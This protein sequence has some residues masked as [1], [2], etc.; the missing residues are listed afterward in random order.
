MPPQ[1]DSGAT[2]VD[3]SWIRRKF[4]DC[5]YGNDPRQAV[6]IYLPNDGAGPFPIV[7]FVHGG[8]WM[9]GQKDD[10]QLA[11]FIGG[12]A[13]GYAVVSI[14]YRL[15]PDVRYPDNLFD[16]KAALRWVARNAGE[17]M[18]D[19]SRTALCGDSAGAHLAMMA[20]FT[21]GVAVF[22][23]VAGEPECNVLAVVE[24][25]GPT[26]FARIY[27]HFEESGVTPAM[28]PGEPSAI[29]AMLGA[30]AE[31]IPNLLRFYNPI[32]NVHPGVPPVLLQHGMRD[33][34]IPY[35]QAAVLY[36]KITAVAGGGMAELDVN[37]SYTH[38]DPGYASP[39]S[40]ERIY[41]FIG[42]YL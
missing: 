38:A 17:Y 6:D 19:P 12:A 9:H 31:L 20:A 13:R 29:D 27:E 2:L 14:G 28:N 34:I 18:L 35:Q 8:T 36:E 7:F 1:N 26:D 42:K 32:D 33:S 11:P 25:F 40:V 16:V 5:R 23:D 4:L 21:R 10:A 3:A 41:R 39:E 24:Q 30:R 22:G 37:E 15:V